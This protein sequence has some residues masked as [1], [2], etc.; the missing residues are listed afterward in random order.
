MTRRQ[1]LLQ[2]G[3]L[4]QQGNRQL[5]Q[6]AHSHPCACD[7]GFKTTLDQGV[8]SSKHAAQHSPYT[9]KIAHESSREESSKQKPDGD[10]RRCQMEDRSV[11]RE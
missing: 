10:A 6:A 2:R 7:F 11:Q 5:L 1:Q 9:G 8:A 3:L 4:C